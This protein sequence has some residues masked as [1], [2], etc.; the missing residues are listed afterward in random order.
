MRRFAL[1]LLL[2]VLSLAF[3]TTAAAVR[4]SYHDAQKRGRAMLGGTKVLMLFAALATVALMAA[5]G[6]VASPPTEASGT[7]TYL[8]STF[9]SV[10]RS[11]VTQS[12][13]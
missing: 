13:I 6:A 1:I 7:F 11:G 3:A 8:S 2:S 4:R 5:P 9:S 10:R 12:S